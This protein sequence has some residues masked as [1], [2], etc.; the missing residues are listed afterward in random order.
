MNLYE[1]AYACYLYG[2]FTNFD[3]SY[4]RF[5]RA[6]AP[7][8]DMQSGAHRK[9]LLK[10][11]NSWGCRQFAK[12]F[13]AQASENLKHWHEDNEH[14]LPQLGKQLLDL[15]GDEL[16]SA[17]MAYGSLVDVQA[18]LRRRGSNEFSKSVGPTG[19][20]KILFALRKDAFPPWD[21][22]IRKRL[23]YDGVS[24]SYKKYLKDVQEILHQLKA[25]CQK[26]GTELSKLPQ[27]LGRP[28]S[29]LVELVDE[30]NWITITN[31]CPPPSLNCLEMWYRWAG[32]IG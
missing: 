21:I 28:S 18:S 1:L 25:E 20:A 7:S 12:D 27:T 23:G 2:H 22:K 32:G 13:H 10:W 8:F 14:L 9:A 3:I 15:S 4:D 31:S 11:L 17:K 24:P 16:D 26:H 29:S 5:L 6:T 30:Y 19:A